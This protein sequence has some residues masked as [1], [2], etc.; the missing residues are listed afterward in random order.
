VA[1]AVTRDRPG[2]GN[3]GLV[4]WHGT[5]EAAGEVP[6]ARQLPL[7]DEVPAVVRAAR[8]DD[9]NVVVGA[10]D[11]EVTAWHNGDDGLWRR[12][13]LDLGVEDIAFVDVAS[14]ADQFVLAGVD[15]KGDAHVWLSSDGEDW[16]PVA[17]A[18]D[19]PSGVSSVTLPAPLGDDELA[20]VWM[21]ADQQDR[22]DPRSGTLATIQ[23]FDGARLADAGVIEARPADGIAR[24]AVTG[25]TMSP[26]G[27]LVAVGRATPDSDTTVPMVWLRESDTWQPSPQSELLER[28]GY[29]FRAV[30][31]D[32]DEMVGVITPWP[33]G[34]DIEL[35]RWQR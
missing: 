11:G 21:A 4:A 10:I 23:R 3:T 18:G 19:L 24:F 25:A 22:A 32:G 29:Q 31:T 8:A 28:A 1:V 2:G 34:G 7:A 12:S 9:T 16:Q 33:T 15:E 6:A 26:E 27:H 30:A 17:S 35:W 20:V 14:L 5:R 13:A